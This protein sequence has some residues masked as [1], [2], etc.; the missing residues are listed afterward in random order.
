MGQARQGVSWAVFLRS[1]AEACLS[2]GMIPQAS[3]GRGGDR[4]QE[5]RLADVGPGGARAFSGGC[6]GTRDAPTR[7]SE[8]V[9]PRAAGDVVEVVPQPEAEA[10]AEARHRTPPLQGV[11]LM[12]LGRFEHSEVDVAKPRIVGGDARE[13]DRDTLGHRGLDQTCGD[14]V[15]LGLGG[16]VVPEGREVIRAVGMRHGRQPLTPFVRPRH[17]TPEPIARGAHGGGIDGGLG[18]PPTAE[19]DGNVLGVTRVVL[20]LPAMD[21]RHG[22]GM[23]EDERE[24]V[25]GAHIGEPGPGEQPCG[26]AHPMVAIGCHGCQQ[27]IGT[28]RHM[29]VEENLAALVKETDRP[30]PGVPVDAAVIAMLLTGE[31]PEGSAWFASVSPTPAVPRRSAEEGASISINPVERTAHSTRFLTVP[32]VFSC[33]PRLTGSVP[34]DCV[35]IRPRQHSTETG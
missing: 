27:G 16:E 35:A 13:V 22:A 3:D 7:G 12:A 24:A 31:A 2:L 30:R 4:P 10:L 6:R 15:T 25:G 8:R 18:P 14:A 19:Q 20:S 32:C 21:R 9:D 28:G 17:A 33:G 23:A 5:R 34:R 26:G 29:A 1:F 11:G